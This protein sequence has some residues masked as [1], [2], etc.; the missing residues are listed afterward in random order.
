[1]ARNH[2]DRKRSL[3]FRNYL[4]NLHSIPFWH[5]N[6]EENHVVTVRPKL[7]ESIF[8][9]VC[10][11]DRVIL[12]LEYFTQGSANACLVINDQDLRHHGPL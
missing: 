9:I 10:L 7:F 11:V 4:K 2:H 8:T 1:M 12:V 6:I 5:F 3:L